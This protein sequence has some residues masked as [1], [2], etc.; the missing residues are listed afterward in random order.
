[1]SGIE[2]R[3][4]TAA[5]DERV[6]ELL[7]SVG[8]PADDV[9]TG[10]Q[11]YVLAHDGP[12]L[13]GTVG[14]EVAG[15]DALVRSLAV[16]PAWRGRGVAGALHDRALALARGRG[17]RALYLLTTTAEAYA[18]RKGFER[19]DRAEVPPAILALPQ[20]RALCPATAACMR[21]RLG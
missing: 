1:M 7:R 13:V 5:D 16:A 11:E 14:L 2:L 6:R 10:P 3:A 8:L 17:V 4:A 20:F 12:R 21:L 18:A 19:I 15:P 9:A